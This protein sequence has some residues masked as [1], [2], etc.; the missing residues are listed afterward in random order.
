MDRKADRVQ[1]VGRRWEVCGIVFVG[2]ARDALSVLGVWEWRWKGVLDLRP[3]LGGGGAGLGLVR[4]N[5][6][7]I[8]DSS[9][10]FLMVSRAV[11]TEHGE[12]KQYIQVPDNN[13]SWKTK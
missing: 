2:L 11:L 3:G 1:E 4:P 5:T 7:V 13:R 8:G 12:G 9:W 6:G 10:C